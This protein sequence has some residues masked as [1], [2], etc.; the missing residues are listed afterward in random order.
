MSDA[1]DALIGILPVAIAGGI[2]IK[3]ADWAFKQPMVRR[4]PLRRRR[5][6]RKPRYLDFGDFRNIGYE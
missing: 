6:K 4:R 1:T 3:M 2:A 5:M